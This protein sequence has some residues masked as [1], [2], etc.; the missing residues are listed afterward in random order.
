[1]AWLFQ[2][3]LSWVFVAPCPCLL[4]LLWPLLLGFLKLSGFASV[5]VLSLAPSAVPLSLSLSSSRARP[6]L[7]VWGSP[8]GLFP[9]SLR[10]GSFKRPE[11]LRL[12][13]L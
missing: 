5:P 3:L 9:A 11:L 12:A 7:C 4:Q 13:E 10:A 2:T 6:C 8:R 1:M